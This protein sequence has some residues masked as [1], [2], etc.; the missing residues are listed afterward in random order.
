MV[1]KVIVIEITC[2]QVYV[3]PIDVWEQLLSGDLEI[4]EW[5]NA[6]DTGA[7]GDKDKT[8]VHVI[9]STSAMARS[10]ALSMS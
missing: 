8:V 2:K 6:D 9:S 4:T 3:V 1:N 7:T 10:M 5:L